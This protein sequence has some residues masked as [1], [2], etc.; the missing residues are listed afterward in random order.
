M[1][2]REGKVLDRFT[3]KNG[4]EVVIRLPMT[5]DARSFMKYINSL[6]KGRAKILLQKKVS[7]QEEKKW[8]ADVISK[9]RKGDIVHVCCTVGDKIVASMAVTKGPYAKNITGT[10][11]F[12]VIKEYRRLGIMK[13]AFRIIERLAKESGIEVIESTYC[14]NNF[15]SEKLHKYFGFKIVGMIPKSINHHGKRTDLVIVY[16]RLKK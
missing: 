5:G 4:E 16:E 12:G 11:S 1:K 6:V 7:L 13:K 14:A 8:L 2:F 9:S 15:P 10:L 3:L